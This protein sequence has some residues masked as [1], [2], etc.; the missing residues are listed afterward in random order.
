MN[1]KRHLLCA[2]AL[3]V[4]MNAAAFNDIEYNVRLGYNIGGTAP[5]GLPATIRKLND[6]D[7]EANVSLCFD[8]KTTIKGRWGV[9][10][11]LHLENKGMK[12]DASVKNYHMTI[13]QDGSY[14]EGYFT[15]HNVTKVEEW[16]ITVPVMATCNVGR[17]VTLK[18]GPYLSYV[19]TSKFEGDVYDGYLR[20]DTPTGPK[21][22]FGSAD[23]ERG[24]FD[25][26]GDMRHWQFGIDFGADWYFTHRWGVYADLAWGVTGVHK[27][28]FKTIE[29]TLYPIYG[30]VGVTYRL[31]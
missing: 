11:G 1:N 20:Q 17:G 6:Y 26:S 13:Q 12:T 25:F 9:M 8:V 24:T 22:T 15:G 29:Q 7:F 5:V 30:T 23:N 16:L 28:S 18:L 4:T 27:S 19:L 3:A 14:L 2:A 10:S 31:K 21:V